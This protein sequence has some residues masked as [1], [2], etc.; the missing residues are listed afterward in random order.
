MWYEKQNKKMNEKKYNGY[1]HYVMSELFY[2]CG[3]VKDA[4]TKKFF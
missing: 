3:R 1:I 4:Q 2:V